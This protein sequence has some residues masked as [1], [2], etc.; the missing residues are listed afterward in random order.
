MPT[1]T[2][3]QTEATR[4]EILRH[5]TDLFSRYGFWKTNIGDIA[6][7]CSMSPANLYRYFRNK[8]AIGRAVVQSYFSTIEAKMGTCLLIPEG[9]AET[10]IRTFIEVGVVHLAEELERNPRIVELADFICNDEDGLKDLQ[11]HICWKRTCLTREI[12]R[13]IAAGDLAPCDPE[14]RATTL[15]NALKSFW[16][17]M[18]MADWR[19]RSTILP[20]LR[21]I[22]DL[23]FSGIRAR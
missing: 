16:I 10:R 7:C 18:H 6:E 2:Q 12:E 13:G 14:E 22:L 19:D 4:H 9:T 23:M 15:L 17:P 21:A 3:K 20:E 11:A 1:T 5:A 8:Q